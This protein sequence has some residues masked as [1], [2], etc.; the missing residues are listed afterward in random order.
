MGSGPA[1]RAIR[2]DSGSVP[3]RTGRRRQP[4]LNHT[5]IGPNRSLYTERR[6]NNTEHLRNT[7]APMLRNAIVI[8]AEIT[9]LLTFGTAVALWALILSPVA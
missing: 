6:R 3:E 5:R 1:L 9:S 2:N 8:A 4:S 7:E